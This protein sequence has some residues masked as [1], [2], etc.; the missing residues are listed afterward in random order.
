M[1]WSSTLSRLTERARGWL[2]SSTRSTRPSCASSSR[3]PGWRAPRG[4]EVSVCGELAANPL[5]TFLLLGLD[6][7][8]LSVAW[9]ALPEVKHMVRSFRM[10]D[11]RAAAKKALAA[12]SAQAVTAALVEGIGDSVDLSAFSGRWSL[13]S[14][15]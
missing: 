4:I 3:S 12:T 2:R 7:T 9:P 10:E 13:S 5:G 11:A 8:A 1:T 14:G 6:I 15:T